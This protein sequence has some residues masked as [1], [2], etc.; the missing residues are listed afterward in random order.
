[1]KICSVL[2]RQTNT[3]MLVSVFLQV[4]VANM[5][6]DDLWSDRSVKTSEIY[7]RL[8]VQYGDNCMSQGKVYEWVERFRG[9]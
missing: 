9:G 1:V 6:I 7:G 5:P 8:T 2:D 4:L 3:T